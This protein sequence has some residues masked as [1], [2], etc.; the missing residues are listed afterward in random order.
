MPPVLISIWDTMQQPLFKI[1]GRGISLISFVYFA[2]PIVISIL[3]S[4]FVI[5]VLK[6]NVYSKTELAKGAQYT[7][8]RLIKYVIMG[9]GILTGVQMIGFNLTTIHVFGGLFGIGVGF[10]LQNIF[11]NFFSG[12]ILLLERPI[13]VGDIIE[14]DRDFCRV[15][16]IKFRVTTVTTFDNETVLVPNTKLITDEVTNW[17]YRGDTTL[18]LHIPIGVGYDSDVKQVK[19]L[20]TE[21]AN[22][23]EHVVNDPSPRAYFKEHGDSSLN[24]ELLAWINSPVNAIP[25]KDSIR[26]KIDEKFR[27]ENIEI[28]YPQRDNHLFP[29]GKFEGLAPESPSEN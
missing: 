20:L 11:S 25:V 16:E 12:L 9:L 18:R 26:E 6:R 7:L 4:K 1:G 19:K 22:S 14:I 27:K 3:V 13:E 5:R 8:S 24:F 15:R 21:I 10:G 23:E 2:I 29:Q 17:S 28:P